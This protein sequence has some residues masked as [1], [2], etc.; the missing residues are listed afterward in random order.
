[1]A[2][3]TSGLS[4]ET[5]PPD[6]GDE[7]S[8]DAACDTDA[9]MD[10]EEEDPSKS[11]ENSSSFDNGKKVTM[12]DDSGTAMDCDKAT[13]TPGNEVTTTGNTSDSEME[14][15]DE[16]GNEK[17][18]EASTSKSDESQHPS[19]NN[20]DVANTTT[21]D[22][23]TGNPP[24]DAS[25]PSISPQDNNGHGKGRYIH[26]TKVIL[27][28][29]VDKKTDL[30]KLPEIARYALVSLGAEI[31]D[32]F[33]A[34]KER[35]LLKTV[36]DLP[37]I[38][39]ATL[40]PDPVKFQK[41][42]NW[43][44]TKHNRRINVFLWLSCPFLFK[45]VKQRIFKYLR[46]KRH[47][48]SRHLFGTWNERQIPVGF[49]SSFAPNLICRNW[50]TKRLQLELQSA[51]AVKKEELGDQYPVPK[52][53]AFPV[54][55]ITQ[56]Q[57]LEFM[58]TVVKADV[59][60]IDCPE[61]LHALYRLLLSDVVKSI[62]PSDNGRGF[63]ALRFVPMPLKNGGRDQRWCG[64]HAQKR[65]KEAHT[66]LLLQGVSFQTM[67]SIRSKL[68]A[69]GFIDSIYPTH[70]VAKFGK[71]QLVCKNDP[72]YAKLTAFLDNDL[73]TLISDLPP[74]KVV[75]IL[76]DDIE[77]GFKRTTKHFN[78]ESTVEL[79]AW[80][81]SYAPFLALREANASTGTAAAKATTSKN[82]SFPSSATTQQSPSR[83]SFP[84]L[85][86]KPTG[87]SVTI[88]PHSATVSNL[89][90]QMQASSSQL[91]AAQA[92]VRT[93]SNQLAAC[94]TK[95]AAQDAK[96]AAQDAKIAALT[97]LLDDIESLRLT[98]SILDKHK[99]RLSQHDDR[100][101]DLMTRAKVQ[102]RHT[103]E[104]SEAQTTHAEKLDN[105]MDRLY[106]KMSDYKGTLD[107]L[108]ATTSKAHATITS[109]LTEHSNAVTSVTD[110]LRA[111]I[112]QNAA[113]LTS[114]QRDQLLASQAY[115]QSLDGLFAT[116]NSIQENQRSHRKRD[117]PTSESTARVRKRTVPSDDSSRP[118]LLSDVLL[119]Q[120]TPPATPTKSAKEKRRS[121]RRSSRH[122]SDSD[123]TTSDMS[124]E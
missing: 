60:Q 29:A 36:G 55:A 18:D 88:Q 85:P 44:Y 82:S 2:V 119:S 98:P 65:W 101:D 62:F 13:M 99:H 86:S 105:D 21:T 57:E 112:D 34:D 97:P 117:V 7:E 78:R 45:D 77:P 16:S 4:A 1:M 118:I 120:S 81:G 114:F 8:A 58:K 67:A 53:F 83:D 20:A 26:H 39:D 22:A 121:K 50:L 96:I 52:D 37:D 63:T 74:D 100:L 61:S 14:E 33:P 107:G 89:Q 91:Q 66:S 59:L 123:D 109:Q 95:I 6:K 42:V 90:S 49:L 111:R 11:T 47:F 40:E 10:V 103:N 48:F 87:G 71:W 116:V 23:A 12:M 30:T 80:T 32:C 25:L 75:P 69:T 31:R 72:T 68:L 73:K 92:T 124:D 27:S 5:V 24:D 115:K 113:S 35:M 38:I 84:A 70:Q 93:Q 43:K 104:L 76:R 17:S 3:N 41:L 102:E 122:D 15:S 46:D 54:A 64:L 94:E 28:I 9:R 79:S 51:Y 110:G 19:S 106:K 56:T 108:A